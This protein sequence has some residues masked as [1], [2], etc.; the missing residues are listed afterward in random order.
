MKHAKISCLL[1]AALLC[2]ALLAGCGNGT[3][4]QAFGTESPISTDNEKETAVPQLLMDLQGTYQELWPVVLADEYHQLWVENCSDL[5]GE[6]NAEATAEMLASMVTGTLTG[7]DAVNAYKDGDM[8]YC[9]EFCR[10]WSNSPL[11]APRS[12]A[13]TQAEMKC[14]NTPIM[15]QERKTRVALPFS[16]V[17][18]L[19][20]ASLLISALPRTR[21]TPLGTSNPLWK[22]F[23][24]FELLRF[25]RLR[26]LA[27]IRHFR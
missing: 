22:R 19:I 10:T 18:M 15:P 25:R 3:G 16:R 2:I 14:S 23:G 11:T 13:Q 6:E 9:C 5:V 7:E 17:T 1:L 20:Q 8:A 4:N 12:P 21:W 24:R 27:G 26:I